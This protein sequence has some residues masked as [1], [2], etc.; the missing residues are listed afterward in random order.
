M[1]RNSNIHRNKLV[2]LN[3]RVEW[4]I[5]QTYNVIYIMTVSQRFFKH[6]KDV[7]QPEA[8][9]TLTLR[10]LLNPAFF[11]RFTEVVPAG[12][13]LSHLCPSWT[14]TLRLDHTRKPFPPPTTFL[15]ATSMANSIPAAVKV[16]GTPGPAGRSSPEG[17][18][19]SCLCQ[20]TKRPALLHQQHLF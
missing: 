7:Y 16:I 14:V 5:H 10:H 1:K 20:F 9:V 15:V 13:N 8:G 11:S 18:Q 19:V 17:S 4:G 2:E 3:K 12:D 6:V